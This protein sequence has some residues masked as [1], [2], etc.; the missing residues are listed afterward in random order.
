MTDE[1]TTKRR[2]LLRSV[3]DGL[4]AL[5][6]AA[7]ADSDTR[8]SMQLMDVREVLKDAFEEDVSAQDCEGCGKTMLYGEKHHPTADDCD[9]CAE[10]A[11]SW[12]CIKRQWDGGRKTDEDGGN[13]AEFMEAYAA[14]I[15][16]G[17]SP[18][19]KV[20]YEL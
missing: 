10:C 16:A 4:H 17:G 7:E 11:P 1:T 15:A 12:G 13:K 14:H 6:K 9:L 19:D 20:L 5:G 3:F 8:T 2:A 18:D